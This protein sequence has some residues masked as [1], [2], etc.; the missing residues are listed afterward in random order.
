MTHRRPSGR[1]LGTPTSDIRDFVVLDQLLVTCR[2]QSETLV[3]YG[4]GDRPMIVYS[5]R[6]VFCLC[7]DGVV[8]FQSVFLQELLSVRHLYVKQGVPHAKEGVCWSRHESKGD[9]FEQLQ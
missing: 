4:C 5:H 3:F 8:G 2:L 1:I 9:R 7:Q 6:L